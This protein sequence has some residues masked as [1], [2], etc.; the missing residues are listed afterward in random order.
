VSDLFFV[1]MVS[2]CDN[3]ELADPAMKPRKAR[4]GNSTD[5]QA[6]LLEVQIFGGNIPVPLAAKDIPDDFGEQLRASRG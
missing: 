6:R 1:P 4:A 5:D 3:V 2:N